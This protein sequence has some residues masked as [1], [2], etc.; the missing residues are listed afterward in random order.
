MYENAGHQGE[1]RAQLGC[2]G[3]TPAAESK[4]KAQAIE[5]I[6]DRLVFALRA[7]EER[8]GGRLRE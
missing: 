3:L 1:Y 2:G 7:M 5:E 4:S 6:V 8:T